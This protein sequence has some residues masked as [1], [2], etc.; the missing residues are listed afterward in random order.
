MNTNIPLLDES[1]P[2]NLLNICLVQDINK[3]QNEDKS[4][5]D[6]ENQTGLN[7]NNPFNKNLQKEYQANGSMLFMY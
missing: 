7:N 2:Q 5:K 4:E 1:S 6:K 3:N